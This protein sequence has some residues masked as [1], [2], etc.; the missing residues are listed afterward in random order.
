MEIRY[1]QDNIE[2]VGIFVERFLKDSKDSDKFGKINEV[3]YA[4][5]S[6]LFINKHDN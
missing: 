1:I 4:K 5:I 6:D 2:N 3:W